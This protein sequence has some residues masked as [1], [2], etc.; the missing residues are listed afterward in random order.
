MSTQAEFSRQVVSLAWVR[1]FARCFRCGAALRWDER[2]FGWSAHHRKPR[3]MGGSS[4]PKLG[5]V[6]NLLILCGSGTSGC[7]GWVESNR[8]EAGSLGY[9]IPVAATAPELDPDVV[10]VVRINGSLV[11]LSNDGRV[12][13]VEEG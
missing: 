9:L 1:E 8:S 10:P 7:H 4:N 2:G 5:E 11:R 3:G 6:S 12:H 13:P